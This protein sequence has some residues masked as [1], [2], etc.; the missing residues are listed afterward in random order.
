MTAL[1]AAIMLFAMTLVVTHQAAGS[2]P[3]R[4]VSLPSAQAVQAGS[5]MPAV[6][7]ADRNQPGRAADN[8]GRGAPVTAAAGGAWSL[9]NWLP[10]G[11]CSQSVIAL[12][13]PQASLLALH[14][15]LNS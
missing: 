11:R 6:L 8:L 5:A 13:S 15:M 14:C 2:A 1:R 12:A 10:G 7:A 9:G 4:K 3:I